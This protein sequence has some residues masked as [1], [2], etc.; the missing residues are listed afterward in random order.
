MAEQRR[1]T[2][3]AE[4]HRL[5][6]IGRSNLDKNRPAALADAIAS[7]EQTDTPAV[8]RFA[9]EALW[10]VPM[11]L[12]VAEPTEQEQ[13]VTAIDISPDGEWLALGFFNGS[14]RLWNA[15]GQA[16]ASWPTSE[17]P[18]SDPNPTWVEFTPDST[19]LLT[20]NPFERA[21][22]FWALPDHRLVRSQPFTGWT[23]PPT[24][25]PVVVG[26]VRRL[27]RFQDH[28]EGGRL[29]L[30]DR[31]SSAGEAHCARSRSRRRS[32]RQPRGSPADLRRGS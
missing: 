24:L 19:T 20:G 5:H 27:M 25:G 29:R 21:Y 1:A 14:A 30:V 9:V 13:L 16:V 17:N 28:S 32:R 12:V 3:R 4:A 15:S 11:P 6:Q 31:R 2:R 10:Q 8:R 26:T 7:L 23:A 18:S 22:R